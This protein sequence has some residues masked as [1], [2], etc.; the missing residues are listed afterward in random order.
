MDI[1]TVF[2][3]IVT[4]QKGLLI[5]GGEQKTKDVSQSQQSLSM[6]VAT[7]KALSETLQRSQGN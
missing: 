1:I 3:S 2:N 6:P 7:I 4:Q 5:L